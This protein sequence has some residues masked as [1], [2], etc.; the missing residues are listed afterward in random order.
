MNN[1]M[2]AAMPQ[3]TAGIPAQGAQ[4]VPVYQGLKPKKPVI[5][6]GMLRYFF[7]TKCYCS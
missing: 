4:A 2:A 6:E 5:E 3:E 7:I 1:V